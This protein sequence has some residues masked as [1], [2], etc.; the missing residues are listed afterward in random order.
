[1]RQCG[2]NAGLA[3]ELA[4]TAGARRHGGG[5]R[6]D[7][8][9][10]G[11]KAAELALARAVRGRAVDVAGLFEPLAEEWERAVEEVAA[12]ASAPAGAPLP[13]LATPA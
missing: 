6:F 1:M 8:V 5:A 9:S 3:A 12:A 7:R 13:R 4:G 11:M 2:A 10:T